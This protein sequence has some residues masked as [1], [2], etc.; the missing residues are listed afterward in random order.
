MVVAIL[1]PALIAL[2]LRGVSD[3]D[4]PRAAAG[5]GV[6]LP[7]EDGR[8]SLT[9]RWDV[10]SPRS[11][12]SALARA[13]CPRAPSEAHVRDAR[14]NGDKAAIDRQDCGRSIGGRGP[15]TYR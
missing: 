9:W 4:H 6:E 7:A 15:W 11:G 10:L 2:F 13:A 14:R 3:P 1:G 12:G 5:G 8:R